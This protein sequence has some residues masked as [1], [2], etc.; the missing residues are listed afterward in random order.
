MTPSSLD[1][2]PDVQWTP[3]GPT[4]TEAIKKNKSEYLMAV[5]GAAQLVSKAIRRAELVSFADL[6]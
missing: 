2:W 4:G 3:D 6:G 5:G 1:F